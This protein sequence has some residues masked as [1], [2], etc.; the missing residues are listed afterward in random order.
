MK[1]TALLIA[2]AVMTL[3]ASAQ[4]NIMASKPY[5]AYVQDS[6]G[7][8]VRD[9]YGLCWHTGFWTSADA[10]PGCDGVPFKPVSVPARVVVPVAAPAPIVPVPVP[11][12]TPKPM[13]TLE[14]I[15]FS[16]DTLFDLNKSTLK[17]AAKVKLD[18]LLSKLSGAQLQQVI[19]TGYTDSTGKISYNQKLSERRAAA[20]QAYLVSKQV[21]SGQIRIE[22]KGEAQPVASNKTRAGR[23][24]NR[25][26]VIEVLGS[27]T[28]M[29]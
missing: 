25:R 20:V 23:A 4:E 27:R 15:T 19:A 1:K 2:T 28:V 12:A 10:V 17:P 5:S 6:Q 3:S 29:R 13:M 18:D 11:A 9:P 22:G 7:I 8:I 24:Q 14:K 21:A 16:A 26:V